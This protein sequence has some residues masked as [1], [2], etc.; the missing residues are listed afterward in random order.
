MAQDLVIE[1]VRAIRFAAERLGVDPYRLARFLANGRLAE[2][3]NTVGEL[4]LIHI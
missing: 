4:S 1:S 3:L 2:I